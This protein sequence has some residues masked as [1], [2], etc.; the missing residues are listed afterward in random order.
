MHGA[1]IVDSDGP[2]RPRHVLDAAEINLGQILLGDTA[3]PLSRGI[4]LIEQRPVVAA[5]D[6]GQRPL[7]VIDIVQVRADG[8]GAVIGMW[9]ISK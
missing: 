8:Q 3:D 6:P 4:V 7:V 2:S 9:P 5:G 1:A